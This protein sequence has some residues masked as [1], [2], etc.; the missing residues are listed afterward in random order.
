[1]L[2]AEIW[3]VNYLVDSCENGVVT[4]SVGP[5]ASPLYREGA[6]SRGFAITVPDKD[7]EEWFSLGENHSS[8]AS[9]YTNCETAVGANG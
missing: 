9:N 3:T 7:R 4:S 1:M 6:H 2:A 5:D 8:V